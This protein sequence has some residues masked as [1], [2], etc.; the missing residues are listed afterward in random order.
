MKLNYED[1]FKMLIK[2]FNDKDGISSSVYDSMY[3]TFYHIDE[4]VNNL[5]NSLVKRDN[6]YYLD[7]KNAEIFKNMIF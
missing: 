6:R 1:A 4:D 5:F 3:V 7:D 2:I